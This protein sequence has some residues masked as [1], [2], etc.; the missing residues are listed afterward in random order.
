[1]ARW[2]HWPRGSAGATT[3]CHCHLNDNA[4]K[5]TIQPHKKITKQTSM[6]HLDFW[7]CL[8]AKTNGVCQ[9]PFGVP[10]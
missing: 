10:P 8:A 2:T 4:T 9:F 5:P 7:G 3:N 1:M 6:P